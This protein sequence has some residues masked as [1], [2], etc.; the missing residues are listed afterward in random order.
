[1]GDDSDFHLQMVG[2]PGREIKNA[3]ARRG[4]GGRRSAPLPQQPAPKPVSEVLTIKG[5]PVFRTVYPSIANQ[6]SCVDCHNQLQA[7]KATGKLGDVMGAFVDRRADGRVPAQQSASRRTGLGA[8][9]FLVMAA[10]G[11]IFA[12]YH[13][14]KSGRP[15]RRSN[16]SPRARRASAISPRRH[17]TG[18]GSRTRICASSA[19]RAAAAPARSPAT[20]DIG[21]TRHETVKAGVTAEQW[22]QHDADLAARRPFHN[23]RFQRTLADGRV[24]HVSHQRQAGLRRQGPASAAIAAPAATSRPKSRSR[25]SWRAASRSAPPS[26]SN[27]AE[28]AGAQRAALGARASSPRPWRTSCAIR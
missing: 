4:D 28:R 10:A 7:G 9:I 20:P 11:L 3:A 13:H 23:F 16:R 6:Q 5:E 19:S 14:R 1:M 17:R 15:R 22:A 2:F 24:I 12:L 8:A 25:S 27:G 21:K 26:C 18:S